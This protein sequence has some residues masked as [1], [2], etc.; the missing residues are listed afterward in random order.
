MILREFMA[1]AVPKGCRKP[2]YGHPPPQGRWRRRGPHGRGGCVLCLSRGAKKC[3]ENVGCGQS[4]RSR[5]PVSWKRQRTPYNKDQRHP[6]RSPFVLS[7]ARKRRDMVQSASTP[8]AFRQT[9]RPLDWVCN[10]SRNRPCGREERSLAPG[11]GC[12][13]GALLSPRTGSVLLSVVDAPLF[14]A[15]QSAAAA[16]LSRFFLPKHALMGAWPCL[17]LTEGRHIQPP[18]HRLTQA[19]AKRCA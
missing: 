16:P 9:T 17:A 1:D 2:G 6:R 19:R 8:K 13:P 18:H 3:G 14:L 4:R 15:D 12:R 7:R 10:C 11:A 5:Q